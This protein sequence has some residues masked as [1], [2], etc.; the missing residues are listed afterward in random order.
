MEASFGGRASALYNRPFPI[1][2]AE[3]FSACSP[4]TNAA[5]LQGAAVIVQRGNCT[6]EVKARA[7]QAAGAALVVIT[8]NQAGSYFVLAAADT[9]RTMVGRW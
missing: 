8:D 5:S 6:F 4:L 2:V 1:A 9:Q 7:A 3:P